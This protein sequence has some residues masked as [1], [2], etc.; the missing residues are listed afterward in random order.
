MS[1]T[2]FALQTAHEKKV[3]STSF[4]AIA[5]NQSIVSKFTG[6]DPN[7]VIQ[8]I[9]ELKPS[10]KGSRAVITLVND[11]LGWGI[12]GDRTLENNGEGLTSQE[13]VVTFDQLRHEVQHEGRMA[14][15]K[16]IIN[17]REEA[18]DKLGYWMANVVDTLAFLTMSGRSYTV[19]LDGAPIIGSDLP[20]LAYASEVTPP[21]PRRRGRWNA[22]TQQFEVGGGSNTVTAADTP[23]WELLMNMKT[24]AKA[25]YMRGLRDGAEEVYHVFLS[26]EAMLKLKLSNTYMLNLRHTPQTAENQKLFTGGTVKIDNLY[27]HETRYAPC[28]RNATA[29]N[30][31]GALGTIDGCQIMMVGSQALAMADMG[32]PGWEEKEFDYGNRPGIACGRI[33]GFKKPQFV[34][35]AGGSV[36]DFGVLSAFVAV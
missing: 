32:S 22:T 31:F 18:R 4:W 15:Q 7:S 36:E 33:F 17:F 28:T 6:G 13:A 27:L 5:R 24:Y 34:P 11:L 30:K 25:Q 2:N 14:E 20:N 9:K 8:V 16:S 19:G 23:T 10:V 26:P 3:W 29:G 12:A 1:M 35:R 21:S